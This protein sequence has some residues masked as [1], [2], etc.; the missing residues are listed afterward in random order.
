MKKNSGD[1]VKKIHKKWRLSHFGRENVD[2]HVVEGSCLICEHKSVSKDRTFILKPTFPFKV[3]LITKNE[4]LIEFNWKKLIT[5]IGR[6]QK[7]THGT[8][9]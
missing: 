7:T 6:V 4:F 9:G 1:F 2:L 8:Q 5:K 3:Y